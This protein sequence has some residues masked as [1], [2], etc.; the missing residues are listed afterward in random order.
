VVVCLEQGADCLDMVIPKHHH[1]VPT[2]VLGVVIII[3]RFL[4][5]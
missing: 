2:V 4:F 5:R 1:L 3:D